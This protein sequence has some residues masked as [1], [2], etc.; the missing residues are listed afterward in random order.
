[1][2]IENLKLKPILNR[3][4][5]KSKHIKHFINYIPKNYNTYIEPF[6]GSGAL[7]LYLKPK[8]WIIN[9]INKDLI[10]IWVVLKN[11]PDYLINKIVKFKS[12]YMKLNNDNDRILYL[13]K[14]TEKLNNDKKNNIEKSI[15]WLILTKMSY[16]GSLNIINNKY[17][18]S[19]INKV[20]NIPYITKINYLNLINNINIFIIN[21]IGKIYNE[22]YKNVLKKAKKNDFIFLDPPY[23]SFGKTPYDYNFNQ[24]L[25]FNFLDELYEEVKKLD[26]KGVKWMMTQENTK[27]VRETFKEYKIRK[28]KVYR[29]FLKK[30]VY[31]LFITNY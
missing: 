21:T 23:I 12:K 13:R 4:G 1:M 6:V 28:Y 26:K 16:R 10:N 27:E 2:N 18:F 15:L 19:S 31:E 8:K 29:I 20:N 3:I 25:T 7:L 24:N 11:N 22:D 30:Y 5:N 9:D 14:L 17:I